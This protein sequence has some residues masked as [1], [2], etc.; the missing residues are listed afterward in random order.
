MFKK[1][2]SGLDCKTCSGP[3]VARNVLKSGK[4]Q[5]ICVAATASL[6]RKN[7]KI[8]VPWKGSVACVACKANFKLTTIVFPPMFNGARVCIPNKTYKELKCD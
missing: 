2:S 1:T 3:Y 4:V 8:L 6:L 7:C 5:S